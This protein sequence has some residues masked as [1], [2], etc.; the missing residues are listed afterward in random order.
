MKIEGV[1]ITPDIIESL[2]YLQTDD[3][4][5]N[6]RTK[7]NNGGINEFKNFAACIIDILLE[8]YN[9]NPEE[10]DAKEVLMCIIRISEMRKMLSSFAAPE[11]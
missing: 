1:Y 5:I 2:I 9:N 3:V 10:F 8:S 6:D 4:T 7:F 11:M